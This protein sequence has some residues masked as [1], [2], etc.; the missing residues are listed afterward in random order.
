M[1][2]E[3]GMTP[4]ELRADVPALEETTYLNFGAHG[5]SPRY[6]VDAATSFLETHE[7]DS[8][9][10]NPYQTAYDEYDRARAKIAD[11]LGSQPSEIALTE[12][13]TDGINRFAGAIKFEPDDVVVRTDLEH[14]AGIL[15]WKRLEARGVEVRVVES[16]AGRIDTEA[17]A[18]AVDGA[19]LACFSAITWTHGTRLPVEELSDIARDAG[20][21]SLVD[22]VQVPGQTPIDVT[23]WGADVV[24]GA[25]HKWLLG[26][27][28]AGFMYIDRE[29]ADDLVPGSIGY[30]SVETPND[31]EITYKPGA[32]RFEIGS[33]SPMPHAG[34]VEAI[35]AIEDVGI[36]RIEERIER[37]T[38]RLKDGID[39]ERLLSPR[40][41]ESGLVTI[42]VEDPEATVERFAER[43]IVIRSLPTPDAVRVS[44][45]AVSTG[46]EID[47]VLDALEN[48]S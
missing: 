34:L 16:T 1:S 20:T 46:R 2:H 15:P 19:T 35:E 21:I 30:R 10:S 40:Q 7:Y 29:F 39:D 8:A 24:V 22:A 26:P 32:P 38:H 31:S 5:P 36:S 12:S 13:T 44:V 45:H 11:L 27:W 4:T 33:S 37:L 23:D 28:G 18:D 3:H 17:F 41:F 42:D 48:E 14:P 6:V 25:G 9:G 43:G 47:A